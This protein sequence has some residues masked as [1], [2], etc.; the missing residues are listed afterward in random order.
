[1]SK[2]I[3]GQW[4]WIHDFANGHGKK[5]YDPENTIDIKPPTIEKNGIVTRWTRRLCPEKIIWQKDALRLLNLDLNDVPDQDM[6][7]LYDRIEALL[8]EERKQR[9]LSAPKP[10]FERVRI[11]STR[12]WPS[13]PDL[14]KILSESS[15][16][17]QLEE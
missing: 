14:R 17:D 3:P 8:I 9:P 1:M 2:P 4:H 10:S 15:I 12:N 16:K 5:L 13:L 6:P 7:K 11:P